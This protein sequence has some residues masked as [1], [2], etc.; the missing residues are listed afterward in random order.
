MDTSSSSSLSSNDIEPALEN[1]LLRPWNLLE[2][3]TGTD[4]EECDDA[5]HDNDD[6]DGEEDGGGDR[7]EGFLRLILKNK[8]F[9]SL[10]LEC[11]FVCCLGFWE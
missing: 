4:N 6:K 11:F 1:W 3:V 10:D 9:K 2:G 7:V 8:V 5:D